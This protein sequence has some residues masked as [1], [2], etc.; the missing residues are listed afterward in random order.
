[1]FTQSLARIVSALMFCALS[2]AALA[3]WTINSDLSRLSFVSMKAT[4]I[5]EVHKFSRF[6]GGLDEN[7]NID[8]EVN[9]ASLETLIPIRN[10]RMLEF[11]FETASFPTAT[12]TG[13]IDPNAI[14][15]L[16]PGEVAILAVETMV[17]L[18]QR[19]TPIT[20]EVLVSKH[21]DRVV[22][23]SLQPIV[24]NTSALGLDDGVEKLREL[25]G[26]PSISQSVPVSL[27]M[28]FDA[29]A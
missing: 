23:T 19:N 29:G 24:L 6:S 28:T 14:N 4:H 3:Q 21:S 18:K 12:I 7:G 5:A 16:K 22:V 17:T 25:A 27:V 9:L 15:A 26:L 10:E 8:I 11:L 1:M 20:T 2:P 13:R